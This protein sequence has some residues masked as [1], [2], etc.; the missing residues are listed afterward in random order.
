M[1]YIMFHRNARNDAIKSYATAKGAKIGTKASN[2]NAGYDAY[3]FMHA[4]DFY[5]RTVI[6]KN[7]MN[8]KD[9]EIAASERGG[10]C[11]PSTERYW[12]M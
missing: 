8:G 12:S 2:R 4:D 3:S 9:V 11:D 10:V 5:Q 7:L 6:V 1:V